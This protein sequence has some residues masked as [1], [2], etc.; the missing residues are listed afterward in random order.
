MINHFQQNV[1]KFKWINQIT[2]RVSDYFNIKH[3]G[4]REIDILLIL[5]KQKQKEK[6]KQKIVIKPVP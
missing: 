6:E 2:N 3:F 1:V 4:Y 5:T